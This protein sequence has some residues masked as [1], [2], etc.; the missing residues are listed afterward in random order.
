MIFVTVGTDT[1]SFDRL[2]KKIDEL[3]EKR[4]IKEEVVAQIGHSKYEPKNAKWFRFESYDKM[5]HYNKKARI[6]ITHGGVGSILTALVLGKSVIAVPRMKE[7][8]EHIDNHQIELVKELVKENKVIGV[9]EIEQLEN[10]I[11]AKGSRL[12]IDNRRLVKE[13][14]NYISSLEKIKQH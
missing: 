8:N 13:I 14:E 7:L 9:F 12:K 6:V 2:L 4:K 1:N 10:K 11:K 3:I 5:K